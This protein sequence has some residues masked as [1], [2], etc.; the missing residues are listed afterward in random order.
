MPTSL[1]R[2]E[3]LDA[4]GLK[5]ESLERLEASG[6][7]R[8]ASGRYD[9]LGVAAAAARYGEGRAEGADRRLAAVAAAISEVKPALERLAGLADRAELKGAEHDRAM[10]EVAAFFNAFA[11]AMSRATTVLNEDD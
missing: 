11:Q 6:A 2:A 8:D 9:P 7:I 10:V 1:T 4:L 5:A 3:V